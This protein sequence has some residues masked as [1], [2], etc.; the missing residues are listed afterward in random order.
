MLKEDRK[1]QLLT[2]ALGLFARY[3]FKKTTL[4]DVAA[5]LGMTKSN[6]YFYALNKNDLYEKTVAHAL[7]QWRDTVA[8]AIEQVGD[9]V[10]KFKVMVQT[11]FEYIDQHEDLQA[12]LIQDPTIFTLSTREDR[13]YEINQNARQLLRKILETGVAEGKFFAMDIEHVTEFLF[14]IYIMFLIKA[15]V[16]SENSSFSGIYQEGLALVLRG[17]CKDRSALETIV[18]SH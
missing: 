18:N 17:L 16:K 8:A 4:E 3:G 11:S 2:A 9:P 10:G 13:F 15:Y 12:V 1:I 14:S 6:I 5:A 7:Q